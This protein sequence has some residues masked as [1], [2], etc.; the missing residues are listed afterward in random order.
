M[1]IE[2]INIENPN[3]D[4]ITD[5]DDNLFP[6]IPDDEQAELDDTD[7]IDYTKLLT[8]VKIDI[9]MPDG[10]V[11][12]G[13]TLNPVRNKTPEIVD[14]PD[15]EN[16]EVVDTPVVDPDSTGIPDSFIVQKR[17]VGTTHALTRGKYFLGILGKNPVIENDKGTRAEIITR[18][19]ELPEALETRF[20]KYIQA[21]S[22]KKYTKAER[23]AL[24]D[25]RQEQR[26]INFESD[27]IRYNNPE[28]EEYFEDNPELKE[29]LLKSQKLKAS[30]GSAINTISRR[31]TIP[32]YKKLL[33]A[34]SLV[35]PQII[36]KSLSFKFPEYK[37]LTLENGLIK[38]FDESEA[39]FKFRILWTTIC[40][41]IGEG[42]ISLA[43]SIALGKMKR[44]KLVWNV[45]FD[46]DM[47]KL[48][49][50][51]DDV[52]VLNRDL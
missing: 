16:C 17:I 37:V 52:Y 12:P 39:E 3:E 13:D 7:N 28:D 45:S 42:N 18:L 14:V 34:N 31:V 4:L 6:E 11:I 44:Q 22:F 10:S 47:E 50:S 25:A 46:K 35:V 51:V 49:Q 24:W 38:A 40:L 19:N 33:V 41:Q 21:P 9:L 30:K 29:K 36:E 5:D 48:I 23:K 20:G 1:D 2:G 8:N 27:D 32:E 43:T 15:S 26:D